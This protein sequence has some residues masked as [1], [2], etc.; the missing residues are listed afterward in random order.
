MKES[1]IVSTE[2]NKRRKL[3]L[4]I[5]LLSLF[6]ILKLG[7]FSKKN[8]IISCSPINQKGTMKLLTQDGRL[9][10]VDVSKIKSSKETISHEELLTWVKR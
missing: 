5:G 2:Q 6:P 9:V 1:E 4:G 3:L 10:E 7:L 8:K